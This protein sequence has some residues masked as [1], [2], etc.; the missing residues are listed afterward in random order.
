MPTL[1]IYRLWNVCKKHVINYI[2]QL[3]CLALTT[4]KFE[5]FTAEYKSQWMCPECIN[6]ILKRDNTE[7][8][9]RSTVSMNKTFTPSNFANKE[10]GSRVRSKEIIMKEIE[11]QLFEEMGKFRLEMI[12]RFDP[13]EGIY[14]A[15]S[16]IDKA[17]N[18]LR[19]INKIMRV[20]QE[21]TEKVEFN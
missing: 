19:E 16:K 21:K 14:N 4:E 8:P 15:S 10:R 5:A 13:K 7:T 12:S 1:K 2:Y 3:K 17:E 20:V 11:Y 18:E 6:A 9:I